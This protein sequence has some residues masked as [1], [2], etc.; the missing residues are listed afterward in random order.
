MVQRASITTG[1]RDAAAILIVRVLAIIGGAS[2]RSI[3]SLSP[4]AAVATE[5][6][7]VTVAA[8]PSVTRS[9]VALIAAVVALVAS[10]AMAVGAALVAD[11]H[12]LLAASKARTGRVDDR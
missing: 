5:L 8:L 6:V 9:I 2:A 3:V 1:T 7:L 4:A 12:V 10:V 11:G